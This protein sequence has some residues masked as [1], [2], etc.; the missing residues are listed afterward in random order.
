[1]LSLILKAL[2][3]HEH[4]LGHLDVPLLRE[5]GE[6]RQRRELAGHLEGFISAK[7]QE[8]GRNEVDPSLHGPV[9]GDLWLERAQFR[10]G[11]GRHAP[12]LPRQGGGGDA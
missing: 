12:W 3:G 4:S 11:L 5:R 6:R 7:K 8:E 10:G 9:A 1:M 2:R